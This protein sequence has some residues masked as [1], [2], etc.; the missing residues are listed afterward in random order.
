M[1]YWIYECNFF[2]KAILLSHFLH[3]LPPLSIA[4]F[5]GTRAATRTCYKCVT[6]AMLT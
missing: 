6:L 3:Y 5:D 2:G 4:L 1:L